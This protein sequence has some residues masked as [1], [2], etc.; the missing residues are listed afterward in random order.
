MAPRLIELSN[1]GMLK[2]DATTFD[3]MGAF[4][5]TNTTV[6]YYTTH[7]ASRIPADD[8]P[9]IAAAVKAAFGDEYPQAADVLSVARDVFAARIRAFDEALLL[10]EELTPDAIGGSP[11]FL[12]AYREEIKNRRAITANDWNA[13]ERSVDDGTDGT[14]S[15]G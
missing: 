12:A 4:N 14:E 10:L 15:D 1:G 8:V 3:R 7:S 6:W 13:L 11:P 5:P 2:V 9:N